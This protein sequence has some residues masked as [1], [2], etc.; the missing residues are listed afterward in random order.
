MKKLI[1]FDFGNDGV[2]YDEG[3]KKIERLY[4]S[5]KYMWVCELFNRWFD[6]QEVSPYRDQLWGRDGEFQMGLPEG[7]Y[8]LVFHFFDPVKKWEPFLLRVGKT[9]R[10]AKR[11][12]WKA[13][14][15]KMIETELGEK[16]CVEMEVKHPGGIL[17]VGFPEEFF[18]NGLDVYS[19][20]NVEFQKIYEEALDTELPPREE[21]EIRGSSDCRE[22][23]RVICEWLLNNRHPDGFIGDFE[24]CG[25]LWY[26][27]SYPIR[28]LLAGYD[29]FG[30]EKYLDAVT[31]MLDLLVQ[32][33]MPEGSFT[34]VYRRQITEEMSEEEL[35]N[36]RKENWMNLADVGSAV[37]ALIAACYYV[38]GERLEKYTNAARNYLDR[39]AFRFR[40][41][42]GGFTNGWI[43]WMDEKVYSVSTATTALSCVL[44]YNLTKEDKYLEVANS[45]GL[46]MAEKWN[47]DGRLWNHIFDKTFPG[48]DHYQR[49]YEFGD[50]FYTLETI[51][52]I[53]NVT[54]SNEVRETMWNVLRKYL[55]GSVGLLVEKGTKAWWDLDHNIWHNSKSAGNPILFYDFIRFGQE[56][57]MTE[58]EKDKAEE[59]LE[60][61]KK[62]IATPEYSALLGVMCEEPEQEYPFARHSIQCW[63]GCS[64]AA[65]GFAGIALAHMVKPGIIFGENI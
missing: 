63:N 19:E 2:P 30:D 33:Q 28:T 22:G 45:A 62:F 53:L 16:K 18:I 44:F 61:C 24:T 1:S 35:E 12:T 47:D 37:A 57:G 38:K 26:T 54:K 27:A 48:H 42:E 51:A 10:Y 32:E 40:Q 7:R 25:R 36:V 15:E 46:Y 50:G 17:A 59:T 34:Q 14:C 9:E 55:F 49:I 20:E 31:V 64:V 39:W 56:F 29:I 11:H 58:D 65:T 13:M 21:V 43:R 60:L 8:R 6:E 41:P 3:Y 5:P 23:L 4:V 52:A